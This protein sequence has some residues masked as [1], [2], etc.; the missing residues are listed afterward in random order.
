MEEINIRDAKKKFYKLSSECI[1]DNKSF[2]IATDKG[3][4]IL[5]NKKEYDSLVES[6][7]LYSIPDIYKSIEIVTKTPTE[8]LNKNSPLK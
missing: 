2:K 3:N 5:L 7:Y 6:F 4:V 8:K 1:M